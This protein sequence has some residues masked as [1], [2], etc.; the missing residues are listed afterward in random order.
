MIISGTG[1]VLSNA[2]GS[3]GFNSNNGGNILR[4]TNEKNEPNSNW[5][6]TT[7]GSGAKLKETIFS[8]EITIEILSERNNV[9]CYID[10]NNNTLTL[11]TGDKIVLN[12]GDT[13]KLAF[14]DSEELSKRRIEKIFGR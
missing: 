7:A 6:I 11:I 10:G 1:I 12:S 5:S 8:Q 3:T 4:L 9:T 14:F 2:L 13:R